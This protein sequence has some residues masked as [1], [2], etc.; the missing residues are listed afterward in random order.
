MPQLCDS[1]DPA[2]L[3]EI[4][5]EIEDKVKRTRSIF[6]FSDDTLIL[7]RLDRL[8]EVEG[9]SSHVHSRGSG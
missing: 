7:R 5:S 1:F 3:K 9:E 2:V 8:G 4:I 6:A